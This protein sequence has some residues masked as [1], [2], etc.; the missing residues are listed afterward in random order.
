MS[1]PSKEKTD[2]THY[3]RKKDVCLFSLLSVKMIHYCMGPSPI[4]KYKGRHLLCANIFLFR[5]TVL[6][7]SSLFHMVLSID[8]KGITLLQGCI[9]VV[10]VH[11]MY[12][13][14]KFTSNNLFIHYIILIIWGIV[15]EIDYQNN[16]LQSEQYTAIGY[17]SS[18]T[19]KR[20]VAKKPHLRSSTKN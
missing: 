13:M 19:K 1:T 2:H 14:L 12:N 15:L 9:C 10:N 8:N 18:F 16:M 20:D 11:N 4:C 3:K 17:Y 7:V 5:N 6:N